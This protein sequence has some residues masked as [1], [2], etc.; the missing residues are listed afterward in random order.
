MTTTH[1]ISGTSKGHV[2][3]EVGPVHVDSV[4]GEDARVPPDTAQIKD[5]AGVDAAGVPLPHSKDLP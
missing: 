1:D 5:A 3:D 2:H 4:A